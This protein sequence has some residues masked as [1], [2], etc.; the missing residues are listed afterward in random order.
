MEE[1]IPDFLRKIEPYCDS[2]HKFLF[3]DKLSQADFWIGTLYTD[4]FANPNISYGKGQW[5]K[6]LHRFPGFKKFGEHYA[7]EIHS[8]LSHRNTHNPKPF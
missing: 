2:P 8:Y 3:G 4:H 1:T 5:D 7:H 6:I